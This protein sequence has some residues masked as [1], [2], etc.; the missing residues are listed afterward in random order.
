MSA[1]QEDQAKAR[2]ERDFAQVP[3]VVFERLPLLGENGFMLFCLAARI[4]GRQPKRRDGTYKVELATRYLKTAFGWDYRRQK[5][6]KAALV[7]ALP[8]AFT[9]IPGDAKTGQGD[10]LVFRQAALVA[11]H[12]DHLAQLKAD[13]EDGTCLHGA[14]TPACTVQAPLPA[15][16]QHPRLHGASKVRDQEIQEVNRTTQSADADLGREEQQAETEEEAS[17]ASV[18]TVSARKGS[19]ARKPVKLVGKT[20]QEAAARIAAA[21]EANRSGTLVQH[22]YENLPDYVLEGIEKALKAADHDVERVVANVAEATL[23]L[24][25]GRWW[26]AS[27]APN[28]DVVARRSAVW[29]SK[30]REQLARSSSRAATATPASV[31]TNF[32]LREDQL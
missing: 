28:L 32:A 5:G 1:P 16:R 23:H 8:E 4:A 26:S 27:T 9:L 24:E 25:G 17:D 21:Y 19:K 15:P 12:N 31:V 7:N 6:A 2:Y 22:D 29:A 3:G 13:A 10:T 30:R 18:S 20:L 14:S 11:L